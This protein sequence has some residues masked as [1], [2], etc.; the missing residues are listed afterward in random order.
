M[1]GWMNLG[2]AD[3]GWLTGLKGFGVCFH[4]GWPKL[5]HFCAPSA[6]CWGQLCVH[7]CPCRWGQGVHLLAQ[8]S[9]LKSTA[10]ESSVFLPPVPS[11]EHILLLW[12]FT[13]KTHSSAGLRVASVS[14]VTPQRDECQP[15][16]VTQHG[17][18]SCWGTNGHAAHANV[19]A[20][21]SEC[22]TAWCI[23]VHRSKCVEKC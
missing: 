17:R 2:Q 4:Q 10:V 22:V 13:A 7:P 20:Y 19:C 18:P 21:A 23:E 3:L 16:R 8:A 1:N 11:S 12:W 5:G 15:V 14:K 6:S 9:E